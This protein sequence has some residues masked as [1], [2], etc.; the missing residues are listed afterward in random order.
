MTGEEMAMKFQKDGDQDALRELFHQYEPLIKSTINSFA[1][2]TVPKELLIPEAK[3]MVMKAA[4]SF[5]PNKGNITTHI[6]NNLKGMHRVVNSASTLYIPES[7]TN[8]ITPFISEF[9]DLSKTLKR[10]PT[11]AEM[12]DALS[13][14]LAEIKKLSQETSK[15]IISQGEDI[16]PQVVHH[17]IDDDHLLEFVYNQSKGNEQKVMEYVYGMHGKGA[18]KTNKA[19]GDAIGLSEAGVRGVKDRIAEKIKEY[20]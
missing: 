4:K 17:I 15:K 6:Q 11:D 3:I 8:L 14:P 1:G 18:M 2:S 12:A 7:R 19:I 16:V 10:Y 20:A 5:D 9:E 13:L